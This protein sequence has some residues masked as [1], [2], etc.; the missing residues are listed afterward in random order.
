MLESVF[1]YGR[2]EIFLVIEAPLGNTAC[3]IDGRQAVEAVVK[4]FRVAGAD[5]SDCL[6]IARNELAACEA[7]AT[8]DKAMQRL[9]GAVSVQSIEGN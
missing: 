5:F 1:G 7:T 6:I 4:K 2:H 8:L 9:P 3:R